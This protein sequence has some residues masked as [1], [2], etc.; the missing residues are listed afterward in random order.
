MFFVMP[1]DHHSSVR[2]TILF[3]WQCHEVR[4]FYVLADS[5]IRIWRVY[6]VVPS[7]FVT[8]FLVEVKFFINIMWRYSDSTACT[9]TESSSAQVRSLSRFPICLDG[10]LKALSKII[11]VNV[12][13]RE[14]VTTSVLQFNCSLFTEVFGV[15]LWAEIATM[16]KVIGVTLH[17]FEF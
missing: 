10:R 12:S 17:F 2:K 15:F 13:A 8:W 9:Y 3:F 6:V 1:S 16:K 4:E 7:F 14:R 5:I 11:I